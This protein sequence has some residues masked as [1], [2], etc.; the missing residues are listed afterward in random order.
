[1]NSK[2]ASARRAPDSRI[3]VF[4]FGFCMLWRRPCQ[5]QNE[6]CPLTSNLYRIAISGNS[7]IVIDV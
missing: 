1:M 6:M 7:A 5:P 4:R 2:P 3:L